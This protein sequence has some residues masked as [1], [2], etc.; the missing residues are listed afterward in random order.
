TSNPQPETAI[1]GGARSAS[2]TSPRAHRS[3]PPH[4]PPRS[5]RPQVLRRCRSRNLRC[6]PNSVGG[7][8]GGSLQ[9]GGRVHRARPPQAP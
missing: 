4:A 7:T 9:H 8:R 1:C 2:V 5:R 6:R 3:G